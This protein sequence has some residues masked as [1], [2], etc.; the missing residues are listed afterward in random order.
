MVVVSL[1][2]ILLDVEDGSL[3]VS[4]RFVYIYFFEAARRCFDFL[5]MDLSSGGSQL[6]IASSFV[7]GFLVNGQH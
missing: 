7:A 6:I 5:R 2:F 4:L 1:V 3:Y